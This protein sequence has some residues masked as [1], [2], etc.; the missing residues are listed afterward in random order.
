MPPELKIDKDFKKLIYPL[1]E[2]NH[3]RLVASLVKNG[4]IDPIITWNGIIVD[5]HKRYEICTQHHI[6]FTVEPTIFDCKESA[7]IWICRKQLEREKIPNLMR[8][9]LI[10]F[11]YRLVKYTT[12]RKNRR[13]PDFNYTPMGKAPSSDLH[14]HTQKTAEKVGVM[15]HL[16]APSIRKYAVFSKTIDRIEK[17]VPWAANLILSGNYKISQER[18]YDLS[19]ESPH[20]IQAELQSCKK[21]SRKK[22]KM[23]PP[24]TYSPSP[25]VKQPSIKDMPAFDPDGIFTELTLTIPYWSKSVKRAMTST[26]ISLVSSKAKAKLLNVLTSHQNAIQ[27]LINSIKE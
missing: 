17:K 16:S 15:F 13:D 21:K 4:C 2:T 10:G 19:W 22:S 11:Y 3:L 23:K 8:N 7:M 12:G 18:L 1:D 25:E 14:P 20:V 27:E 24:T 9:Y 5:G 6:D 26:D